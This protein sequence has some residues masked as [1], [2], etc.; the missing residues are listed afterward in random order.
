MLISKNST[1]GWHRPGDSLTSQNA[2]SNLIDHV[3]G[4]ARNATRKVTN[5]AYSPILVRHLSPL[6]TNLALVKKHSDSQYSQYM[7][8]FAYVDILASRPGEQ[9]EGEA[10]ELKVSFNEIEIDP[11][12]VIVLEKPRAMGLIKDLARCMTKVEI[13]E[14]IQIIMEVKNA[15]P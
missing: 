2:P 11:H 3:P 12:T 14:V 8:Q 5:D 4:V 13:E 9:S 10:A 7:I 6:L 15:N 1:F